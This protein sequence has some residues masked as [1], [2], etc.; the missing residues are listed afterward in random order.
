MD[1]HSI[2]RRVVIIAWLT[3]AA[4]PLRLSASCPHPEPPC[5]ELAKAD[6]V[7]IADVVE[8]TDVPRRDEQGRPYPDG[9]T[10]YRFNVLEGLKGIAP[11]EFRAQFYFGGASD[12]DSFRSGGYYLIFANRTR[13]GNYKSGCS[14]SREITKAVEADWLPQLQ[15]ELSLCLKQP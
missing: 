1:A 10:N 15:A 3:C 13:T 6:L 9:I 8:S 5:N 2:N 4:I 11:G 7:F 14:L 12:L